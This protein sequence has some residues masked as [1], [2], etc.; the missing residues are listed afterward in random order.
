MSL[1]EI[2]PLTS[3][4]ASGRVRHRNGVWKCF[5]GGGTRLAEVF[6]VV[7]EGQLRVKLNP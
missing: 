7:S 5:D 3:F 2:K 4:P 6:Y 1:E